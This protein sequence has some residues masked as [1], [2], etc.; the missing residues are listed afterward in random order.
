MN[1]GSLRTQE[2]TPLRAGPQKEV[3]AQDRNMEN[4]LK[5]VWTTY[6]WIKP[7]KLSHPQGSSPL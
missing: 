1:E 2:N 7:G 5:T 4:R 3:C 6:C